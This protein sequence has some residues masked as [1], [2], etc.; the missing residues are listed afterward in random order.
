MSACGLLGDPGPPDDD[1]SFFDPDLQ[2][3]EPS[4]NEAKILARAISEFE[5]ALLSPESDAP[6]RWLTIAAGWGTAKTRL[7]KT[8]VWRAHKAGVRSQY[9]TEY[10]FDRRIKDFQKEWD[11]STDGVDP[12]AW[13]ES[14]ARTPFVAMDDIGA[15]VFDR[16][17]YTQ[18]RLFRFFD[19][20]YQSGL[21]LVVS[22]NLEPKEFIKHVG[23]RV[24]DRLC[25]VTR[26]DLLQLWQMRS[27]RRV[28]RTDQVVR[29]G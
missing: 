5:T 16:S 13:V 24:F 15:G 2:E 8:L 21:P 6:A 11:E 3:T 4:R 18:T 28:P 7:I 20:R 29:H 26:A 9:I 17:G 10:T 27:I 23:E 19:L 25:D 14:L 12:D 1:Y 22:T